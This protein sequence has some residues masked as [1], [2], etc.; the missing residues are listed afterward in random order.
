MPAPTATP[1]ANVF[2]SSPN[3]VILRWKSTDQAWYAGVAQT[4]LF[5]MLVT[6]LISA[7]DWGPV[8]NRG[9]TLLSLTGTPC[10][11]PRPS[12]RV[13]PPSS[14]PPLASLFAGLPSRN[15]QCCFRRPPRSSHSRVIIV[16]AGLSG[17]CLSV[18]LLDKGLC[19]KVPSD[20]SP[21]GPQDG[22]LILEQGAEVGGTWHWNRYPGCACD[23]ESYA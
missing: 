22:L 3:M 14:P 2:G 6:W 10:S 15:H 17:I 21:Q 23:V 8:P 9:R 5:H 20:P 12:E 18:A 13:T 19:S 4:Y 11:D 1:T 7:T 16:G